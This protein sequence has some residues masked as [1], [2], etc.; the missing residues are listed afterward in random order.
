[1]TEWLNQLVANMPQYEALL[2]R[3]VARLVG[4]VKAG[5]VLAKSL[6]D[7]G[8]DIAARAKTAVDGY[9]QIVKT[10]LD[11]GDWTPVGGAVG[12]G[13]R[14]AVMGGLVGAGNGGGIDWLELGK[15]VVP[16]VLEFV[17]GVVTA[18]LD[19]IMWFN[20]LKDNWRPIAGLVVFALLTIF[21][22]G[23]G[24]A[25]GKLGGVLE[26]IPILRLAAPLLNWFQR[27][28]NRVRPGFMRFGGRVWGWIWGGF[29]RVFPS[30]AKRVD[31][32]LFHFRELFTK[33]IPAIA[34][35]G[36]HWALGWL[37]TIARVIAEAPWRLLKVIGRF[38]AWFGKTI[39]GIVNSAGTVVAAA[40]MTIVGTAFRWIQERWDTVR[41]WFGFG[42]NVGGGGIIPPPPTFGPS[43]TAPAGGIQIGPH[44]AAGGT[45]TQAGL[46][47][48]GENG[49][50][51]RYMP[52]GASV[53]PLPRAGDFAGALGDRDIH[54][55]VSIDGR[56]ILHAVHRIQDDKVARR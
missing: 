2:S 26:K 27:A 18:L 17:L 55:H 46:S 25:I 7:W 44:M 22:G 56:E 29:E 6:F 48:V 23:F 1:M 41:G 32:N 15:A 28:I 52:R 12:T 37:G 42:P 8:S 54:T 36:K 34:A 11:N 49:P 9:I 3:V 38:G 33:D 31:G 30:I 5:A 45:V 14:N 10:A 51:L 53:I 43:P 24:G 39:L 13:L 19:P 21:T 35:A 20:F 47:W 40:I 16:H 50:E 4:A